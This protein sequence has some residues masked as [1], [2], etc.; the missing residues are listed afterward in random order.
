MQAVPQQQL[1]ASAE[2]RPRAVT[3]GGGQGAAALG[4]CHQMKHSPELQPK[5]TGGEGKK[6]KKLLETDL[7]QAGLFLK[8][9]RN[10]GKRHLIKAVFEVVKC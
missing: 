9:K 8:G 5:K 4:L 1:A 2:P 6:K 3:E 7:S 10:A